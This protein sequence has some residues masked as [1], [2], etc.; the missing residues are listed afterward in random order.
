[1]RACLFKLSLMVLIL[2]MFNDSSFADDKMRFRFHIFI[3][4]GPVFQNTWLEEDIDDLWDDDDDDWDEMKDQL[5]LMDHALFVS[6]DDRLTLNRDGC[7][8]NK[9][10]IPFQAD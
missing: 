1:M 4:S 7:Y 3:I 5:L 8:W 9:K 10:K 6:G 2:S